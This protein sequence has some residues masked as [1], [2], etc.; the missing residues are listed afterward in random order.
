MR[1]SSRVAIIVVIF[2]GHAWAKP[3]KAN[4]KHTGTTMDSNDPVEKEKS[5]EGPFTPSGKTGELK[6][7]EEKQEEEKRVAALPPVK[8]RPRDKI[9][10]FG[11]LVIGFGKAPE[12][13]P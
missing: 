10:A 13:G 8:R 3:K 7:E 6:K 11:N 1:I 4:A 5:D 9:G 2:S 12:P